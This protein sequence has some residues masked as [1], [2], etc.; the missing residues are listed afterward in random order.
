MPAGAGRPGEAA[1]AYATALK[2]DP[3]F[4]EAWFNYGG[5]LR[6]AGKVDAARRHLARAIELDGGYAD[7][8]YNLGAL[9]Y[10][11][12]DLEAARGWWRRYLDLDATSEWA[13]RARA[14][15]A[16]A[17]QHARRTAG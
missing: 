11:A 17:D 3:Q 2:R 7:A 8:I 13:R 6:D 9:E 12:G 15:I 16:I 4:V 14:G 10:D 1:L 5:L